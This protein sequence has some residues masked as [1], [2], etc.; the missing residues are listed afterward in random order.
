MEIRPGTDEDFIPAMELIVEF[1]E[2]SLS[3]YGTYLDPE[4]LK[5][6]FNKVLKTSFVAVVDNK[7]VGVLA[8]HI[9]NDFCSKLPVYE[10]VLWYVN[11][12]HRKYGI[13]LLHYVERWCLKNNIKRITMC[14]MGNLKTDKL[15][16]L[17]EKLGFRIMETR[18]I[19]ELN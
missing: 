10:E 12:E 2:E 6:T 5:E 17:Y 3:E 16:S 7:M 8:G 14:C 1:A 11:K 15:F 18:F 13:K 19:K 9:V 4:R